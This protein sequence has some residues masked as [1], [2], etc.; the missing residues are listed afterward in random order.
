MIT[1]KQIEIILFYILLSVASYA[2]IYFL[3]TPISVLQYLGIEAL[4]VVSH[5]VIEYVKKIN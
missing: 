1:G 5:L 3:I 4:F 2:V